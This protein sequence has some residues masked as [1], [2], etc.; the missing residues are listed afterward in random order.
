MLT[1]ESGAFISLGIYF[2]VMLCIGYYSYQKT[3]NDPSGFA[4]GGRRL[5]PSV[6]ALSAGASDMSGWMLM[7][8]PGALYISGLSSA[9]I[10]IGLTI[11][12]Y[13]NYLLVAPRLRV[14]TEVVDDAVTL[15]QYFERRFSDRSHSLRLVCAIVIVVF[16]AI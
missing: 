6:T 4:L 3:K 11:G 14:Y 13:L 9:W 12:A 10:A 15:P 2:V 16:F 8:L 7:G 5:S 1:V